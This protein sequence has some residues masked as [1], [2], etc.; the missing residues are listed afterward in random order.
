MLHFRRL[1]YFLSL[2]CIFLTFSG[3]AYYVLSKQKQSYAAYTE[4]NTIQ[5]RREELHNYRQNVTTVPSTDDIFFHSNKCQD[6]RR[7]RSSDIQYRHTHWQVQQEGQE[8]IVV[9]SAFYDDRPIVGVLPWIRILGVRRLSDNP[10]WCYVWY[11]EIERPFVTQAEIIRTG[12]DHPVQKGYIYS[13]KLFS[14]KLNSSNFIPT[15]VSIA[16]RLCT[17]STMLLEITH[18]TKSDRWIHNFGV[19][20]EVNF[21]Y[22]RPELIVEW[23]EAYSMFGVTRVN[24]YN[25]SIDSRLDRVFDYYRQKG[26]LELHQMPPAVEVIPLRSQIR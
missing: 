1:Q 10:L 15:H 6:L 4:D 11:S 23:M 24:L 22:F 21:G 25:G 26:I 16:T 5:L 17:K 13:Q 7:P 8:D 3:P 12:A 2:T 14:C 18:L 19:C 9:Y 20:L